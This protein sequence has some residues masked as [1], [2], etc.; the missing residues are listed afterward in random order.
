M[1]SKGSALTACGEWLL[2]TGRGR[3]QSGPQPAACMRLPGLG[4]GGARPG[5]GVGWPGVPGRTGEEEEK[6]SP[7]TSRSC[8]AGPAGKV[9][10]QRPDA[11]RQKL[12]PPAAAPTPLGAG[13]QRR[14]SRLPARVQG[15]ASLGS[16]GPSSGAP[17]GSLVP[18][19][20][21]GAQG[22]GLPGPSGTPAWDQVGLTGP[23][24][25]PLHCSETQFGAL[26]GTL[27][28][29][30]L[31]LSKVRILVLLHTRLSR[32]GCPTPPH[33]GQPQPRRACGQEGRGP[34]AAGG[35]G[36]LTMKLGL[37]GWMR[38]SASTQMPLVSL[39]DW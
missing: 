28:G 36:R 24:S 23:D 21:R 12:P 34:R 29:T 20:E 6:S 32:A 27:D 19:G 14:G 25:S 10:M 9:D 8:T 11:G 31:K 13:E 2:S 33:E 7:L 39:R 1:S 37:P 35:S 26:S 18:L 30:E 22:P 16:R 4:S 17:L 5:Q 15:E 38:S 3:G